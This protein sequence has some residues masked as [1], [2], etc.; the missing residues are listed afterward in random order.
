MLLI[1]EAIAYYNFMRSVFKRSCEQYCICIYEYIQHNYFYYYYLLK[2]MHIAENF[3]LNTA[4]KKRTETEIS[5]IKIFI[6]F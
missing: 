5:S 2:L 6:F 4:Y 3:F 1:S